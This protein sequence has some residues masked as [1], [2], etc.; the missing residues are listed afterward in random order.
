MCIMKKNMGTIDRNCSIQME[1]SQM[2][3]VVMALTNAW[4]I[5]YIASMTQSKSSSS[6]SDVLL[7][8]KRFS[9]LKL[10]FFSGWG[11]D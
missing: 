4:G 11:L 2:N 1:V 9:N 10:S 6:C 5:R 8:S 7:S 3:L